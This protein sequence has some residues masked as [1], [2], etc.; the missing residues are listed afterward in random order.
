[1]HLLFL[2]AASCAAQAP[3]KT[4]AVAIRDQ[5]VPIGL[6][7]LFHQ[8]RQNPDSNFTTVNSA[9]AG[10]EAAKPIANTPTAKQNASLQAPLLC[11]PGTF[12]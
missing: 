10:V 3:M 6:A 8:I 5:P 12:R 4:G 9:R 2:T 7:L 11:H 1:M